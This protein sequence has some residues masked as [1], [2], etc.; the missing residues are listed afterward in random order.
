[1]WADPGTVHAA[2]CLGHENLVVLDGS[3]CC[4]LGRLGD[5]PGTV[6]VRGDRLVVG[7]P[8]DGGPTTAQVSAGRTVGPVAGLVVGNSI[9]G[10]R[11]VVVV[12]VGGLRLRAWSDGAP[13]VGDRV[14]VSV[15]GGGVV[16]LSG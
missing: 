6:L 5:G 14:G 11:T 10:G 7:A 16:P 15:A 4:P 3:G 8:A 1:V 12:D 9:R 2:V 13:I